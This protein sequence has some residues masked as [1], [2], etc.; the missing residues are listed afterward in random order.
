VKDKA[1]RREAAE[2]DREYW[3]TR[4]SGTRGEDEAG[5]LEKDVSYIALPDHGLQ[6]NGTLDGDQKE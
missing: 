2:K 4:S 1:Q 6:R 3:V 5:R